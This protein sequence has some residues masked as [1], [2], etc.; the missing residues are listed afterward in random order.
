MLLWR[1][2]SLP[3]HS[4]VTSARPRI[5]DADQVEYSCSIRLYLA[6]ACFPASSNLNGNTS[7]TTLTSVVNLN[8]YLPPLSY[9][10]STKNAVNPCSGFGTRPTYTP[11]F[12]SFRGVLL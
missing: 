7:G 8:G 4:F 2:S 1:N 3:L 11:G 12:S 5:R 9:T 10:N 6:A